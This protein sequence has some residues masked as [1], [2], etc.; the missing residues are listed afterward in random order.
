MVRRDKS[1]V[2]GMVMPTAHKPPDATRSLADK[3]RARAGFELFFHAG[4][5]PDL[6]DYSGPDVR[7]FG[8]TRGIHNIKEPYK[9]TEY[10]SGSGGVFPTCALD[11]DAVVYGKLSHHYDETLYLRRRMGGFLGFLG[12]MEE[13]PNVEHRVR[14]CQ[15]SELITPPATGDAFYVQMLIRL[16]RPLPDSSGRIGPPPT[17]TTA[18]SSELAKEIIGHLAANPTQ[19]YRL[20]RMLLPR[21]SFPNINEKMLDT[22]SVGS[23]LVLLPAEAVPKRTPG[24]PYYHPVFSYAFQPAAFTEFG[25]YHPYSIG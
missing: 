6:N 5:R 2:M 3:V 24:S 13:Y 23:G 22:V 11:F 20:I 10:S 14:H 19:Y 18:C 15:L 25:T 9:V 7:G 1:R 8:Y 12:I 16:A 21:D 17:L 4:D